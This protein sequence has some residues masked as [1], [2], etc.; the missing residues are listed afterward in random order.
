[1]FF[2]KRNRYAKDI[3]Q[4][5]WPYV[6]GVKRAERWGGDISPIENPFLL[7]FIGSSIHFLLSQYEGR[8]PT[9]TDSGNVGVQVFQHCY[10]EMWKEVAQADISYMQKQEPI[11]QRGWDAAVILWAL[12]FGLVGPNQNPTLKRINESAK[13]AALHDY[14]QKNFPSPPPDNDQSQLLTAVMTRIQ[15]EAEGGPPWDEVE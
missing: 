6:Y 10:P 5:V 7:G 13:T 4:K 14:I 11:Y 1:M 8:S 3:A 12:A 2:W 9:H 15:E